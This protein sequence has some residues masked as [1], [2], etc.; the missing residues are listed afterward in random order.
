MRSPAA[1]VFVCVALGSLLLFGLFAYTSL[2][3]QHEVDV[4]SGRT[5][6]A[7]TLW[8]LNF[9]WEEQDTEFSRLLAQADLEPA[10]TVWRRYHTNARYL[11]VHYTYGGIM[12][13]VRGLLECSDSLN[14]PTPD[15]VRLA[16]A[17][18]Q[19]LQARDRFSLEVDFD[20]PMIEVRAENGTP[21]ERWPVA[22]PSRTP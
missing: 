6:Q 13:T 4:N 11:R 22:S 8:G 3:R 9:G 21:L 15:R 12:S 2:Q 17:A 7:T 20:N 5:R 18:R 14:V 16:L 10:P 19:C 1:K